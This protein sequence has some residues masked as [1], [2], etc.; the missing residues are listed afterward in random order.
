MMTGTSELL[1][2]MPPAHLEAVHAGHHHVEQDGV[3]RALL[4]LRQAGRAVE[5]A[6]DL[7]PVLLQVARQQ[8]VQP[9]IV[10]DASGRWRW[11]RRSRR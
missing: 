10:V 9:Q 2:R 1:E 4:E 11:R 5:G 3:V 8:V 7:E 6:L